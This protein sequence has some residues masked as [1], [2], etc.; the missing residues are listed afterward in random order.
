MTHKF[1][2]IE[3]DIPI[4][5]GGNHYNRWGFDRL[6]V[7]QSMLVE[8]EEATKASRAASAYGKAHKWKL[9]TRTVEGGLR[10]WRKE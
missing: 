1:P 5:Y 9:V 6:K 8:P 2:E 4:P 10:I 3:D 7:G